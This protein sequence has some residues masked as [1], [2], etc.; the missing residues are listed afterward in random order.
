MDEVS[1]LYRYL[2]V[3]YVHESD[4]S[5]SFVRVKDRHTVM[6]TVFDNGLKAPLTIIGKSK[7][8]RNFPRHMY[9]NLETA[10]F[11]IMNT[12]I[13]VTHKTFGRLWY[14]ALTKWDRYR[15]GIWDTCWIISLLNQ[16]TT[17]YFRTNRRYLYLPTQDPLFNLL[18]VISDA[19]LSVLMGGCLYL[20][21][22]KR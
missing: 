22:W 3:K 20:T 11:S 15:G 8:P 12:P 17:I 6:I 9:K 19:R 7:R 13:N 10:G 1:V 21:F 16:S 5:S 2:P 4:V 14:L 18:I